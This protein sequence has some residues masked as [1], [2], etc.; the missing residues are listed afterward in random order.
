IMVHAAAALPLE[1][2]QSIFD[3]NLKGTQNALE[4][5]LHNKTKRFIQISSTAVYGVPEK[6]P[7]EE[8]DPLTPVG[9]YAETK[10]L[11]E[12]MCEDY[13]KKGLTTTIIRPKTFIGTFRLGV[14]QILYDWVYNGVKIPMIGS[15]NNR[16]QL[17]EV[18][19][20]ASAV[21]HFFSCP[22]AVANDVYNVGGT[23]FGTVREDLT[24]L[25]AHAGTKSK[26][27]GT[28]AAPTIL[29]LRFLESIKL[30]PLYKWVYGTAGKNSMVSVDK[31]LSR[32][33]WKP[34]FSNAD[35]LIHAYDWYLQNLNTISNASG[36][37][38]RVPWKQGVLSVAK[39]ILKLF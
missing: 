19:D 31:I 26:P 16:Y 23:D 33:G 13:R 3:T 2:K 10:I 18:T 7:I 39:K 29:L 32:T 9:P 17:L 35:A 24:A 12:K 14:F 11:S 38:H 25:C 27:F 5:A 37:T 21:R 8:T 4:A 34:R 22:E 20:L 1:S 30:S 28:P 15:G 6:F 36:T